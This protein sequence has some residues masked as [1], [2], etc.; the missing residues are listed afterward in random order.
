MAA[1]VEEVVGGADRRNAKCRLPDRHQLPFEIVA[2]PLRFLACDRDRCHDGQGA[3]I[4]LA[5]RG[6]RQRVEPG[7]GAGTMYSGNEPFRKAHKSRTDGSVTASSAG[8][9]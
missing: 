5:V 6:Q 9:R 2:R 4:D 7:A 1:E 3:A 8:T